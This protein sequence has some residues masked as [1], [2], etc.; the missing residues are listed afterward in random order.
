MNYEISFTDKTASFESVDQILKIREARLDFDS[1][2]Y[3]LI[4]QFEP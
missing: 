4:K 3:Q 1:N 2:V